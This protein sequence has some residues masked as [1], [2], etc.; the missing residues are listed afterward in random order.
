WFIAKYNDKLFSEL[1]E[2]WVHGPVYPRVYRKYK[3]FQYSPIEVS[4]INSEAEQIGFLENFS[5]DL[6]EKQW[7]NE[8]FLSYNKLSSE[9]LVF[10]SH[11]EL[12]WKNARN[13]IDDFATCNV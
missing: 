1:P 9:H 13:G 8:V 12:P 6:E 5:L 2:A 3:S 7:I 4:N 10:L 11:S